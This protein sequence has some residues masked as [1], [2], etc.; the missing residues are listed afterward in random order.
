MSVATSVGD[1]KSALPE[2][3][4]CGPI[5]HEG[6]PARGGF[7]AANLRLLQ[8]L[9]KMG[10]A[11]K[12]FP[13]PDTEGANAV[14]KAMAYAFGFLGIYLK[15]LRFSAD[16]STIVHFTPLVKAFLPLE[17]AFCWLVKMRGAKL[18]VDLRAGTQISHYQ[19][20]SSFYRTMYRKMLGLA[21]AIAYEGQAYDAFITSIVPDKP[22][23]LFPN[24]LP[25][26]FLGDISLVE[27]QGGPHLVYVGA[28]SRAKG[29]LQAL[30]VLKI[31]KSEFPDATLTLIGS[32]DADCAQELETA[33]IT[34]LQITGPLSTD[35]VKNYLE[36]SH[37]FLF[38][39]L[40]KG[41]G[42]SNAL[43]EAMGRG[44]VP[45]CTDHGFNNSIIGDCGHIVPDR[46]ETAQISS[47]ISKTWKNGNWDQLSSMAQTRVDTFFSE[48]AVCGILNKMYE[49]LL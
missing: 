29:A 6:H 41:E 19:E 48:R 10:Y 1:A 43:T 46:E 45:V 23:H 12:R 7:E 28:V 32:V 21:D 2:I 34:G 31:L 27:R 9:Q 18:I 17:L 15:V 40:W 33:T 44:C 36:K 14:A 26:S 16:V 11:T 3:I 37:F 13:Y 47:L 42:H 24:F 38:L 5:A 22:R 20:R 30:R 4:V 8:T 39:T 35:A 25:D 49:E